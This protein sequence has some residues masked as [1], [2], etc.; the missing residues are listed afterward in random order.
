[1][2]VPS[3]PG[4]W[5]SAPPVCTPLLPI[6]P[7]GPTLKGLNSAWEAD[8]VSPDD[9][10]PVRCVFKHMDHPG[11]LPVEMACAL[12]ASVLGSRVP[13]PC[14]VRATPSSLSF[15]LTK[16]QFPTQANASATMLLFGSTFVT[17]GGFFEQLTQAEDATLDR[18][19]WNH[20]C[21]ES[22][23]AAKAAALD[24]LLANW[25]RHSR[26]MRFDGKSW[27]LIDHDNALHHALGKDPRAMNADFAAHK[28]QIAS[29]LHT[30]Q[31]QEHGMPNAARLTSDKVQLVQA[32]AARVSLW[33]DEDPVVTHIWQQTAPLIGLLGRR[34][35]MLQS[36]IGARINANQPTPLQWSTPP[37]P[38]APPDPP[39]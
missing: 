7:L 4:W 15:A 23:M 29:Q 37:E 5:H 35:P 16:A 10:E 30:R 33:Q 38:P 6:D 8:V 26:N 13:R 18:A 3:Q 22:P 2:N 39:A 14:L 17:N 27:W 32:L 31:P 1:M 9:D 34:L 28:N 25:D 19:V 36:L 12:T 20:F 24:E 11:K 21:N